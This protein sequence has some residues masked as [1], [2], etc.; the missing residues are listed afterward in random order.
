MLNNLTY[1]KCLILNQG[2]HRQRLA[3]YFLEKLRKETDRMY[4]N[5]NGK[6]IIK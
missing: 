5:K 4:V 3:R 1:E 2:I 6:L